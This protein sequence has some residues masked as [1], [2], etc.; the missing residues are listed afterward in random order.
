MR[1]KQAGSGLNDADSSIVS[2]DLIDGTSGA[3]NNRN[4]VEAKIL[5]VEIGGEAERETLLLASRDFN[6]VSSRRQVADNRI[7]RMGSLWQLQER[8]QCAANNGH[9][10]WLCLA[11]FEIQYCLGRV[12]VD[13][14][15]AKDFGGGE[16]CG[17]RDCEV[18]GCG[19]RLK[20]FLDLVMTMSAFFDGVLS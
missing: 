9:L 15:D 5:W 20:L 17:D 1:I 13:Q 16:G 8:C 18:G 3:G 6:I 19:R 12:P 10:N 2:L 4:Q 7:G 14:L 11:V